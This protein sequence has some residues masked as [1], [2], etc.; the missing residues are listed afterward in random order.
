[1]YILFKTGRV[2]TNL[3]SEAKPFSL[4]RER[5]GSIQIQGLQ[6]YKKESNDISF[7][8][9]K[10]TFLSRRIHEYNAPNNVRG[11]TVRRFFNEVDLCMNAYAPNKEAQLLGLRLYLETRLWVKP[12]NSSDQYADLCFYV[13]CS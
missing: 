1:M 2:G 10:H 9:V 7:P 8:L 3:Q 4:G 6:K 13:K 12:K 5:G 11:Y